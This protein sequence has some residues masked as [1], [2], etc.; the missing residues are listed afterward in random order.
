MALGIAAAIGRG[1]S[2]QALDDTMVLVVCTETGTVISGTPV[3]I[4]VNDKTFISLL[5]SASDSEIIDYA[6]E[7]GESLFVV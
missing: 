1:F 3:A 5:D 4:P 2:M 6:I 7:N